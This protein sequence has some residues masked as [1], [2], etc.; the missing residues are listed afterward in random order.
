MNTLW[1]YSIFNWIIHILSFFGVLQGSNL[2]P[3]LFLSFINDIIEK[4]NW[5]MATSEY[6]DKRNVVYRHTWLVGKILNLFIRSKDRR[7]IK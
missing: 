5:T 6:I 3:F 2:G 1:K 7:P 4:K